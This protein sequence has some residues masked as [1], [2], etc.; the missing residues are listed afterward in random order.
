MRN[1]MITNRNLIDE[2]VT[3]IKQL[4]SSYLNTFNRE[5]DIEK[6]EKKPSF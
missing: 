2:M 4:C 6:E 5:E 1:R 3:Q